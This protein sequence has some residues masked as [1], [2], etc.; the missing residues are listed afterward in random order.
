VAIS[1]RLI[2]YEQSLAM[3]ENKFEEIVDGEIR[4]MPPPSRVHALLIER[5]AEILREQLDRHTIRVITSPF[6]LGIQRNPYL[7][8]RVP[9]LALYRAID[10]DRERDH[11][12]WSAPELLVECLSPAN[13]KGSIEKLLAD[14]ARISVPEVWLL[15][16]LERRLDSHAL[17]AGAFNPRP[18][19][20]TEAIRTLRFPHVS[21]NLEDLWKLLPAE[22][23]ES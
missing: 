17:E 15:Y 10:L 13:R 4:H 3:P 5:M 16:P 18:T 8:Y 11:Y 12:I 20:S 21:I 6:G 2:T 23:L 22:S 14:Y 9:D 7:S 1:T 19:A